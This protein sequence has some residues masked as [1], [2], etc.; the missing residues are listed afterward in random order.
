[1]KVCQELPDGYG[2]KFQLNLQN[3]KKLALWLNVAGGVITALVLIAGILFVPLNVFGQVKPAGFMIR[4]LVLV[5]GYVAYAVLHELT[6]AAVMKGLG[7]V[8]VI[9]GFTGMYAYA[10]SLKDYFDKRAHRL[11][12]I[13]PLLVWGI[14]FG[15]LAALVPGDWFWIVWFWQAG[16]IGGSIGDMFVIGRLWREPDSILVRDTGVDMTVYGK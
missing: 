4:G 15:V 13:A 11:I 10:G 7:G 2:E 12:A 9:F 16:N 3:D 6:H 5:V 14:I 1:M 8:N